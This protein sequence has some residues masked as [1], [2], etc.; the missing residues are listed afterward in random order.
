MKTNVKPTDYDDTFTQARTLCHAVHGEEVEF[1]LVYM[2]RCPQTQTVTAVE[3]SYGTFDEQEGTLAEHAAAG[4][5]PYMMVAV[6][7]KAGHSSDIVQHSRAVA[8][9]FDNGLPKLLE[10]DEL[11]E[12]VCPSYVVTTSLGRYHA[13]WILDASCTPAEMQYLATVIQDRL[14]GDIAFARRIQAVRFPGFLNHKNGD[15]VR[16]HGA[17]QSGKL[18]GYDNLCHAFDAD[19]VVN[20]QRTL[21]HRV[22]ADL[23]ISKSRH[24]SDDM[25]EDATSALPYLKDLADDYHSWVRIGLAL[26]GLGHAGKPLFDKFSAFSA[27]YDEKAVSKKWDYLLKSADSSS[28]RPLFA[29][30]QDAGWK[31]PGFRANAPAPSVLTDREF[32][33][34]CAE[35]MLEEFAVVAPPNAKGAAMFFKQEANSYRLLSN[36]ERRSETERAAKAVIAAFTSEAAVKNAWLKK[37]G[38]NKGVDDLCE[39]VAEVLI[40]ANEGNKVRSYPY[41]PFAGGVL[42]LLSKDVVPKRYRP[43]ALWSSDVVYDSTAT[44]PLFMKV[45]HEIFEQD[46]VMVRFMLRLFGLILLGKPSQHFFIWLGPTASNGKSVLQNV[47]RGVLGPYAS[48]TATATLMVKSHTTDGANP[49]IAQLAGKRLAIT[50]EP[51]GNQQLDSSLIKQ[52]TGDGYVNV[53]NNYGAPYDMPVEFVLLMI[54][55]EMPLARDNDH[56]MWRRAVVIPFNRT[57]TAEDGDEKLPEKLRKEFPGILNEMLAGAHDYLKNGL[58]VPAKVRGTVAEQRQAVD[59]FG[60]F[61]GECLSA[62]PGAETGLK[63]IYE[64][65]EAWSKRNPRF[66]K[67]SKPE[68][69]KRLQ[70]QHEKFNKV[71]L[72]VFVGVTLV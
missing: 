59:P 42:N 3:H 5:E 67:M 36:I 27:E 66:R 31:N 20:L 30:A 68:L 28:I 29:A 19:L 18:H 65:Y 10:S 62:T 34:M 32:G 39:H 56:G 53:R 2:M 50:S 12:F 70:E 23:T 26:A 24:N 71:N 4:W 14:E 16:L 11:N 47:L 54:T 13:V 17:F 7:S 52:I 15:K 44:A 46:E 69:S 37:I 63:E 45:L 64:A 60:A 38:T 8:A 55:N 61:T 43:L 72:A 58:D 49:G 21:N 25:V 22:G 33:A 41:F 51:T 40:L 9:D 48:G 35:V 6:T 1:G 57:F